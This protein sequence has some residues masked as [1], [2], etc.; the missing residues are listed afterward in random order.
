MQGR[1]T[2]A[3]RVC[4]VDG[5]PDKDHYR[6]FKISAAAAGDDFA[7][8]EETVRRSLGRCVQDEDDELPD[9]LLVDGGEGQLAA[10]RRAMAELGLDEEVAV[11]GLAKSR[12]QGFAGNKRLATAERLVVPGVGE[13]ALPEGAP[14]TLLVARIRDEAHR[15]AITYH[16]KLREKLTSDLDRIPGIGP[17][18]RR[19]LLQHFG[20]L[21]RVK[22]A[23]LEELR[24]VPGLGEA[25]AERVFTALHEQGGRAP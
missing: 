1:D 9:L 18:R 6:R 23:A 25:V 13:V 19:R 22:A 17:S 8:M 14:H 2:V 12:L 7:A 3:S 10:A 24:A 21:T 15:F 5:N 20:S 4:F 16:R 11:V